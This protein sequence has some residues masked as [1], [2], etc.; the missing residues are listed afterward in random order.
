M[1]EIL[2]SLDDIN[3]NLPSEENVVVEATTANSDLI[4]VSVARIV[5]GYLSSTLTSEILMSWSSPDVTP[6]IIREIAGKLIAAQLF[7]QE[8]SKSSLD[9][10]PNSFAQLLYNQAIALLTGIVAGSIWI[11]V[12]EGGLPIPDT[13]MST[14]DFFPVDQTDMVFSKGMKLYGQNI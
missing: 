3:A 9:I 2:A 14:L 1:A 13:G 4:Q 10:D 5:R 12:P 8:T 6:Q 11:D 7:F